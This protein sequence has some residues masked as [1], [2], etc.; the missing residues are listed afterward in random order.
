MLVKK[1]QLARKVLMVLPALKVQLVIL[2]PVE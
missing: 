2:D 1:V